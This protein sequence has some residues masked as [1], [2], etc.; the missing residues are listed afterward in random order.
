V[1]AHLTFVFGD[2]F[3]LKNPVGEL[4]EGL[5]VRPAF[6]EPPLSGYDYQRSGDRFLTPKRKLVLGAR[7]AVLHVAPNDDWHYPR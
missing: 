1:G 5:D 7:V 3:V 4:E 2:R 6:C